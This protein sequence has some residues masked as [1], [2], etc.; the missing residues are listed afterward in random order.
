MD[1]SIER[2]SD[3]LEA[4]QNLWIKVTDQLPDHDQTCFIKTT[5]SDDSIFAHYN[6]E[7]KEFE[8]IAFPCSVKVIENVTYFIP[9]PRLNFER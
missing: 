2:D 8:C 3:D 7:T 5:G 4:S 9:L 6:A 1:I